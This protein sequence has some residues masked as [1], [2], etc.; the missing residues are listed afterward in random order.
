MFVVFDLFMDD[1]NLGISVLLVIDIFLV[2]LRSCLVVE[3]RMV[4]SLIWV[5]FL[6]KLRVLWFVF[7]F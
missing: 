4:V 3:G 5:N 1:M 7:F 6:I 2:R